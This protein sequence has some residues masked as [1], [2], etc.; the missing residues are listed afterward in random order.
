MA[1]L[2]SAWINAAS[3][4]AA[5]KVFRWLQ[6]QLGRSSS[7]LTMVKYVQADGC[8]VVTFHTSLSSQTWNDRVVE[9]IALGQQ[10]SRGWT[11]TGEVHS[12]LEGWSNEPSIPGINSLRWTLMSHS[13]TFQADSSVTNY[14]SLQ[15]DTEHARVQR[16][17]FDVMQKASRHASWQSVVS[18]LTDLGEAI[19][20]AK[21]QNSYESGVFVNYPNGYGFIYW[22]SRYPEV[23]NHDMIGMESTD[24]Q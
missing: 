17:R 5:R 14:R 18:D 8:W 4:K 23:F 1:V 3:E 20:I 15:A 19:S 2:W 10:V 13:M 24:P 12:H 7:Q 22:T 9:V 11:L 6:H 21:K 16:L